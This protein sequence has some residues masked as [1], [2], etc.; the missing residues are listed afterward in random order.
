M[1]RKLTASIAALASVLVFSSSGPATAQPH[2]SLAGPVSGSSQPRLTLVATNA[3]GV[4]VPAEGTVTSD[5]VRVGGRTLRRATIVVG[6]WPDA[7][8]VVIAPSTSFA[9]GSCAL[10]GSISVKACITVFFDI[11]NNSNY[12]FGD[13]EYYQAAW[14]RVSSQAT[15]KNGNV[16]P[17]AHGYTCPGGSLSLTSDNW[18]TANPTS[19]ST[20]TY[21][22]HW[23]GTYVEIRSGNG[24]GQK[25][26]SKLT[27]GRGTSTYNLSIG[28]TIPDN[29]GWPQPGGCVG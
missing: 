19:G 8:S 24:E 15:L 18:N 13:V 26:N 4:R 16:S 7:R 29:G 27:W 10:D 1:I 20:Y 14:T 5:I 23:H 17:L 2:G 22:P 6:A 21:T 11:K 3:A 28:Y 9:N 25:V 12:Y